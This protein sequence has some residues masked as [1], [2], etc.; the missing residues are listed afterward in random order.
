MLCGFA[1]SSCD[2]GII[3][4]EGEDYSG[5]TVT[6]S[7]TVGVSAPDVSADVEVET[8]A[9]DNA[10]IDYP[11]P[12]NGGRFKNLV[13]VLV[14]CN[15]RVLGMHCK[16]FEN[17][18]GV[19]EYNYVFSDINVEASH[20]SD[21]KLYKVYAFGNVCKEHYAD[22][23]EKDESRNFK[24][25]SNP[26]NINSLQVNNH[27]ITNII[28]LDNLN[29]IYQYTD[30]NGLDVS[31]IPQ[32]NISFVPGTK[33]LMNSG[34]VT[35]VGMPENNTATATVVKGNTQFNVALKRVCSRIKITF[36]NFT[37]N[38]NKIYIEKFKTKTNLFATQ[39]DYLYNGKIN[40]SASSPFDMI[41][42]LNCVVESNEN[43]NKHYIYES[44]HIHN[45]IE[46]GESIT[47]SMYVFEI[48]I[49]NGWD[50]D[51]KIDRGKSLGKDTKNLQEDNAY[52]I[53][54]SQKQKALA[55]NPDNKIFPSDQTDLNN[56]N[57]KGQIFWSLKAGG[58]AGIY[59]ILH[60][61][62][63]LETD[64]Y[65]KSIDDNKD[66][67]LASQESDN[68]THTLKLEPT[69]E[70]WNSQYLYFELK[71]GQYMLMFC[72]KY[73]DGKHKWGDRWHCLTVDNKK[74]LENWCSGLTFPDWDKKY[75]WTLYAKYIIRND[76][77]LKDQDG[78]IKTIERNHNYEFDF[79]VMPNF[80]EKQELL[81]KCVR[82]QNE[83]NWSEV[84]K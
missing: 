33:Y 64:L 11:Q 71:N 21:R 17:A 26:V 9:G 45:K 14:D 31:E 28:K 24:D 58:S 56:F 46:D 57:Y 38:G 76:Q 43:N 48:Q 47:F 81:V 79:S 83:V 39:T 19:K 77:K 10:N 25:I 13:L 20:I 68:K 1:I 69:F 4:V 75:D 35:S 61:P 6:T 41:Q 63:N 50:Y 65:D 84:Q 51:L 3:I 54:N 60:Y 22:I 23:V 73:S 55:Y 15:E 70:E 32:Y 5:E 67:Y 27:C 59:T 36:R 74:N 49:Q 30:N 78:V 37:G 66:I 7:F 44:D 8:R 82:K 12:E 52:V 34:P 40:Y 2:D 72:N 16:E 80:D 29:R 62:I 42:A 53:W 18:S